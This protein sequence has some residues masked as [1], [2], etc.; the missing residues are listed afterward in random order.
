M[1]GGGSAMIG[2]RSIRDQ[3]GL[4]M[5][6]AVLIS[7]VVA[8]TA[9]SPR[10]RAATPPE[11]ARCCFE[12]M[13]YNAYLGADLQPLFGKSGEDLIRAA[14]N[15]FAQ[16]DRTD[17]NR[18]A[19]A[20]ARQIGLAQP[21]VV[22]LQELS[23]WQTAPTS[24]PSQVTTRYDFLQILLGELERQGHPYRAVS[25]N[26]NFSNRDFPIPIDLSRTT[27]GMFTDRNAIIVRADLPTSELT[28]ANPREGD[29]ET[30]LPV[31]IGGTT[32]QVNRGWASVDLGV[33]G[34]WFR[35]FD[36]HLEAFHPLVRLGQVGELVGLMSDAPYPVVLS[37][38]L[39]IYPEGSRA[40]DQAAWDALRRAGFVDAWVE[41]GGQVPA[42]TAGQPEDVDCSMPSTLDNT[43]DF[44]L[45]D[46]DDIVDAVRHSGDIVGEE[47]GDCSTGTPPLWPSDHAGVVVGLHIPE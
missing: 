40:E 23:L 9:W 33:R 25:V 28:T 47:P 5:T 8:T 43:V 37:G 39:N 42:Y 24:N 30:T 45:H 36:T 34:A 10:A 35:I 46:A 27:L 11:H 16:V 12:V 26:E 38:D 29:F 15:V 1:K 32:I 17:F 20:I 44:V 18:R 3:V 7:M 13:T 22:G 19:Q 4:R 2:T 31:P 41:S 21:E 14:A 6:V